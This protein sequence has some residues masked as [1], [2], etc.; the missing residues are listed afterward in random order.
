MMLLLLRCATAQPIVTITDFSG[1][2]ALNGNQVT[3]MTTDRRGFLWVSTWGGLYRYDG[4]KFLC[5]KIRPGDGNELD[6]A[7]ID[8]VQQDIH[9]NLICRSYGDYFLYDFSTNKFRRLKGVKGY[10]AGR[11][12]LYNSGVFTRD[13]YRLK[14]SDNTLFYYHTKEQRW[15]PLVEHIKMARVNASGIVWARMD[16]ERLCRIMVTRQ[17]YDVLDGQEHVLTIHRDSHG[18]LWQA[19]NDGSVL[20]R[21]GLGEPIGYLS[22][23][24][25]V[26]K[27]KTTFSRIFAIA[28]DGAERVFLGSRHDGL[29]VLTVDSPSYRVSHYTSNQQDPNSL[30]NDEVFSLLWD[31]GMLWIGT[32][33]GGLNLM[34][35]EQGKMVF[36][37]RNN[38]STNFPEHDRLYGIR[39]IVRAGS[40]V[41]LSTSDG[42][43]TC[44]AS[45]VPES[46]RFYHSHRIDNNPRSLASNGTMSVNY[47]KGKGLFVCT[48]HGGL[49]RATSDHLLQDDI[50]F[51]TWNTE[52]GAP[53]DQTLQ[54]FADGE[55][56]LWVIFEG[57]LSKLDVATMTS[58]DFLENATPHTHTWTQPVTLDDGTTCFATKEGLLKTDLRTLRHYRSPPSIQITSLTANGKDIPYSLN[59][60][61]MMLTKDERNFF[62]E[63]AAL[64]MAGTDH[65]EYAYRVEDRDPDWIKTRHNRTLSFFNLGAGT[66]HLLIRATDN[67]RIWSDYVRRVTI[68]V[69]PTFWETPWAWVLYALSA[70]V[71]IA[72]IMLVVMYIY[73]LRLN[74]DFEKRL[75]EM[76]LRYFT[77]IS[78]D[79]RTP[80]TLIEGPVSEMLQDDTLTERNR[81]YLTL[82]R[83][84]TRRM[85]TLVNQILDFRKIQNSK[86]HLLI[87]RM[88]LKAELSEVMADFRYMADDHQIDFSLQDHTGEAAFIWGDRDKVQK[89]FFNL[90]SNAFK[91]TAYGK[92]I[93]IEL[94]CNDTTVSVSV[95]DTG[96]GMPQY[97][98]GRL[99]ARFETIL[100][101]N[102]MKYSSGIGLSLVKELVA[103]HHAQITVDSQEGKGSR[104]KVTFQKGNQHFVGDENT[105]MMTGNERGIAAEATVKSEKAEENSDIRIMVVEDDADMLRFVSGILDSEYQ[106]LQAI[107]GQDGFERATAL[108]PDLII[109][110]INMPRMNGWQMVEALKQQAET[111]H[112]PVVLLTANSTL[113]DRIRGAVQG[114]EDYIIKPFSTEYLRVRVAAILQKQQQQ[115]QYFLEQFA[116]TDTASMLELPKDNSGVGRRLAQIDNDMMQQLRTFM[117]E[118]LADNTPIQELAEHVGMSRT[119]FYNKIRSIT[120]LTPV[121]FYRRYHVERSA[122]LMRDQ[123]LT[124]SE[125]CYRTGFSDPK[126]FS[127]VFKKF[128]GLTPSEYR[129]GKDSSVIY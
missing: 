38:R 37:N 75:T 64:E 10:Q 63:F 1:R 35:H 77:N 76:K 55:G 65:V 104:F 15:Q 79:L 83:N 122:Q 3:G 96:K 28:D 73:R 54:T 48:S 92:K 51:E 26:S 103:L 68:I 7:R 45:S 126:Y 80:L 106:V 53:S 110:D 44:E 18:I 67:N 66:Y 124:V 125:A 4:Y 70:I 24:G 58:T 11:S 12:R 113:D 59:A 116:K 121:D 120:G 52:R 21:N 33:R 5:Y 23:S 107:D 108:Q 127:K 46:M 13:G 42:I 8:D 14:V 115:Q 97:A 17:L 36:L 88:D 47:V 30:T 31:N 86:M 57:G 95:C 78:H 50:E 20:L 25:D 118:H 84:N 6:N 117:E 16:D 34:K 69:Q 60:D 85:L 114:V 49:C 129:S 123:G 41:V 94:E 2:D 74:A 87:E 99:F 19:N 29:Y 112:V 91:Y 81:D 89:I 40:A 56:Q 128:M 111:S 32:L 93:W 9:G 105:Q 72:V 43:F 62:I 90:L 102:Y 27:Q 109:S 98:V 61:T 119:L 71:L 101:D 82:V 100:T 22:S 39:S